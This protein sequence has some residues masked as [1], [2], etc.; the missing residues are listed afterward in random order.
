MDSAPFDKSLENISQTLASIDSKMDQDSEQL[1][2][3]DQLN[4]LA[5][6]KEQ[7]DR[8]RKYRNYED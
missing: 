1:K 8:D 3:L 5:E 7:L 2:K 6:I 4:Q